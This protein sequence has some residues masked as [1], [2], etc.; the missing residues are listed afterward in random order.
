MASRRAATQVVK[1]CLDSSFGLSRTLRNPAS[2]GATLRVVRDFLQNPDLNRLNESMRVNICTLDLE[3]DVFWLLF[4]C[5]LA[6]H[7]PTQTPLPNLRAQLWSM[8]LLK[9]LILLVGVLQ[10]LEPC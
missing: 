10:R 6:R 1:R 3:F 7:Q 5:S 4:V 2:L 9:M 8:I